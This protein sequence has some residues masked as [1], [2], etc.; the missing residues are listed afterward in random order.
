MPRVWD[1]ANLIIDEKMKIDLY[2]GYIYQV[3]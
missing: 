2:N 3:S 1:H